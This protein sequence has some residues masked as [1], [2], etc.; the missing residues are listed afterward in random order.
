MFM[1]LYI[2]I[3]IHVFFFNAVATTTKIVYEGLFIQNYFP[4]FLKIYGRVSFPLNNFKHPDFIFTVPCALSL[5]E[6]N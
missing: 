5:K 4:Y 1:V 3:F 2:W 6:S